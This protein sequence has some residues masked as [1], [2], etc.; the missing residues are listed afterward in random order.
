ML[1][2]NAHSC[3]VA[4][5]CCGVSIVLSRLFHRSLNAQEVSGEGDGRGGGDDW[6]DFDFTLIEIMLWFCNSL[7][8]C[9]PM[10]SL[11]VFIV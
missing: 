5:L 2:N 9:R 6:S 7:F 1:S 4:C 11:H 10:C 8:V 3:V